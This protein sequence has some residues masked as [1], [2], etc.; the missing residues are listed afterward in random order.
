MSFKESVYFSDEFTKYLKIY[1]SRMQNVRTAEEV[2]GAVRV[3]CDYLKM[4]FLELEGRDVETFFNYMA[5]RVNQ[6]TLR[7][8][9][10]NSRKSIYGKL[11]LF[12]HDEYPG[13]GF[14]NPFAL[15]RPLSYTAGIRASK[16]PSLEDVD[17]VLEAS[18]TEPMYY[19]ILSLAFRAALTAS[20]IVS[21]H[22]DNIYK[23]GNSVSIHIPGNGYK[24]DIMIPLSSDL[25]ELL[26]RYISN[27]D[28]IDAE[29][30]LFYNRYNNPM[31]IKNLDDAVARFVSASG[32]ENRYTLQNL[33][34]R[35]I[36]DMLRA[37][38]EAGEDVKEVATYVNIRELRLN[39]YLSAALLAEK[40]PAD[41][42][43]LMV[44][45]LDAD[46]DELEG[47]GVTEW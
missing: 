13:L 31:S 18:K 16:I 36:L 38:A 40:C 7:C 47:D 15:I 45:P 1:V 2:W 35:A 23:D 30:H 5:A 32:I 43:N 44:K 34:S 10:Y 8:T 33:R 12:L 11:A 29:G 39:T 27:M 6:G 14:D 24:D 37:S 46:A 25:S 26:A 21:L 42:V 3:L 41:L 17:A 4:D 22:R 28:Y 20:Q 9:T 19:L